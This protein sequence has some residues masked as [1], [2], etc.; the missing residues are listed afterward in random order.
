MLP[1]VT[2]RGCL[3]LFK[4]KIGLLH[5]LGMVGSICHCIS[6]QVDG[7]PGCLL[8]QVYVV[9]KCQGHMRVIDRVCC[10]AH[11]VMG[12]GWCLLVLV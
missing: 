6:G 11:L 4:K 12:I 1:K 7:V 9:G 8:S 10:L 5:Q 3:A 2:L